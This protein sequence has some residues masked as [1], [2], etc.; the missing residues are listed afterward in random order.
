MSNA[1]QLPAPPVAP[2]KDFII[3]KHGDRRVDP[4]YWMRERDSQPVLDYLKAENEYYEKVTARAADLKAD[5][6]KE[7][8]SRIKE[9]EESVPYKKEDY[10]YYSRYDKGAEYPVF[11]RR[12]ESLKNPEEV[13]LNAPEL[14]AGKKY[15][16]LGGMAISPDQKIL[17][18]SVD[19]VGRRFYDIYFRNLESGKILDFKIEATTGS[20]VW[21]EDNKTLYYIKQ[22][23]NTLRAENAYRITLNGQPELIYFEPDETFHLSLSKSLTK[24]FI[25]ITSNSTLSTE[26][27]FIDARDPKADPQVFHPREKKHE[28][29]VWHGGD[30]FYILTNYRAENFRVMEAFAGKTAR[31]YWKEVIPHNKKVLIDDLAVFKDFFVTRERK[32][33]LN[34]LVVH[35]RLKKSKKSIQFPDPAYVVE[36]GTNANYETDVFRY[37]YQSMGRA[38]TTYDYNVK[39]QK[40]VVVKEKEIPNYSSK[41][42][43]T[44][45]LFATARDGERIPISLLVKK[46]YKPN[47]KNPLFVY[48]YGSYGISIDPG[49]D[50]TVLSLVDRGFAYAILH[51]R[52]GTEKGRYWYESGKLL[53]K[54][55]TF[56]DFIDATEF[57]LKK[58]YGARGH[59]YA[60]GGS[61]G[62]LLMGAV[63]NMRPDLYRGIIAAVPFVD[64]VTTMLDETIPLTTFEYDEW[65]NPNDPK[66]YKYMKSYSPYDNVKPQAYPNIFIATGYHDSQVQYWEPAKWAQR[67]RENNKGDS[68]IL[69]RTDMSAGHSG[70]TGRFQSVEED[71]M[72]YSFFL[73]LEDMAAAAVEEKAA[74]KK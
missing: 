41:N 10:F 50:R 22:N 23:P 2:K 52:G 54:K 65:G 34:Q 36:F 43:K 11:Y 49:F 74:R 3:E 26:V 32:N 51:I 48:G 16:Q 47:G 40:S 45:R 42:Y 44:L 57:L 20:M 33:A 8:R 19:T 58:K 9:D 14:A 27:R 73:M 13:I 46:N 18:F 35:S 4:Y 66:Y 56:N 71:A 17:A 12:R 55:N 6:F 62:G 37:E 7:M 24:D 64:V 5:L 28:Y 70:T 59:V 60:M 63:A 29:H 61:A 68:L 53:R 30:R 69:F 25:F 38:P 67:L 21:A 1:A 31:K 39:K 15:Y 72:Y